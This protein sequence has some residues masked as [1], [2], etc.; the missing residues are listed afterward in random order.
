MIAVDPGE[1]VA[2]ADAVF[3]L[4]K[5]DLRPDPFLSL[6]FPNTTFRKDPLRFR[7]DFTGVSC[8][9]A[10]A[11]EELAAL[12]A[13]GTSR[14]SPSL[15]RRMFRR[16]N[17][18][19]DIER[20]CDVDDFLFSN[21]LGVSSSILGNGMAVSLSFESCDGVLISGQCDGRHGGMVL[22]TE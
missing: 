21:G 14:I 16:D 17:R 1:G 5:G 10:P 11:G 19:P 15:V 13:C 20:L 7:G 8:A 6:P 12:F 18:F 9:A 3:G 2:G 22:Q 4:S